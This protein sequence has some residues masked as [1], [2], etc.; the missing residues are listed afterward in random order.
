MEGLPDVQRYAMRRDTNRNTEYIESPNYKLSSN[1][2]WTS[3][4][5]Y[6]SIFTYPDG[7]TFIQEGRTTSSNSYV[8]P[9]GIMH[10]ISSSLFIQDFASSHSQ[11]RFENNKMDYPGL[12]DGMM[13]NT[14]RNFLYY[15]DPSTV[16]SGPEDRIWAREGIPLAR[17][18]HL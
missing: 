4:R 2:V 10:N 18:F 16:Y 15:I 8:S 14:N 6:D 1:N 3:V 17:L 13:F 9:D 11:A 7:T 5:N 12:F